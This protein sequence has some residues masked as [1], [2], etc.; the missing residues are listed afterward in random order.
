[1]MQATWVQVSAPAVPHVLVV[2]LRTVA[3]VLAVIVLWVLIAQGVQT[4][5]PLGPGT[6]LPGLYL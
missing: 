2:T 6:P 5:A 3:A 1:M 4:D